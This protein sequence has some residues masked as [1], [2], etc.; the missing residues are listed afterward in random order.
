VTGTLEIER[1]VDGLYNLTQTIYETL[2]KPIITNGDSNQ[3]KLDALSKDKQS[4][5]SS[6]Y[7]DLSM[8][9]KS[10]KL[11]VV[12]NQ[13]K[14]SNSISKNQKDISQNVEA[15]NQS[16]VQTQKFLKK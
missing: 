3:Y 6:E 16:R 5:I 13:A 9:L 14:V 8:D 2:N 10:V 4:E 15:I 11:D 1:K 12:I 7:Y